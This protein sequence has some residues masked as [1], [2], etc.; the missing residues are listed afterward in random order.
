M[1]RIYLMGGLGNVLFQIDHAIRNADEVGKLEFITNLVENRF[2]SKLFNWTYHNNILQNYKFALP[3][4]FKRL[5]A[6]QVLLDLMLLWLVKNNII[7]SNKLSWE[8]S[9]LTNTNFGYFQYSRKKVISVLE[10]SIKD[11]E[12]NQPVVHLRLG[13]SPSLIDD[14]TAQIKLMRTLTFKRYIIITNDLNRAKALFDMENYEVTILSNSQQID[15]FILANCRTLIIPQSTFSWMAA[16]ENKNLE[17]LYVNEGIWNK[18]S[19]NKSINIK[20]YK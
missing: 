12:I 10:L 7:K 8:S 3:L 20:T 5:S 16:Y 11:L 18:M 2:Y 19:F 6:Y 4:N 1:K 14:Y 13:D 17:F 15:F 9:T